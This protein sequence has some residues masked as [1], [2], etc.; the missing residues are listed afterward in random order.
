M[1]RHRALWQLLVALPLCLNWLDPGTTELKRK[2]LKAVADGSRDDIFRHCEALETLQLRAPLGGRW[3]LIYSTQTAP[4]ST[5]ESIINAATG[6]LY[7]GFFRFAPFLAGAQDRPKLEL[8]AL[9]LSIG[10]EQLLDL[11]AK[12]VDNRVTLRL[13]SQRVDVRVKGE[14]RGEDVN[15]L[16]V[17]F[18]RFTL[19]IPQLPVV[20]LPL[21]R[22]K[23]RLRTSFCDD[24]MRLSRGGRGG[25]FVLKRLQADAGQSAPQPVSASNGQ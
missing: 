16:E 3:A 25:L 11:K 23:G 1:T 13:G 9:S 15:D 17:I 22:P 21:P 6:M 19:E 14:L 18:D 5:D 12:R 10:N 2:L 4:E 20:E 8:G 24:T 7:Q